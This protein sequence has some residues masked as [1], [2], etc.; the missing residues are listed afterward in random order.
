M[1]FFSIVIEAF[2]IRTISFKTILDENGMTQSVSRVSHCIDNSPMEGVWGTIKSE[3]FKEGKRHTFEN[4]K[5]AQ[6][7]IDSYIKFFNKERITLKMAPLI[8]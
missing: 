5:T 1:V 2:S 8:S 4:L 6:K 3:L 7:E